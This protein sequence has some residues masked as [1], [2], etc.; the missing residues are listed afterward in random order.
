MAGALK[1]N[2][3]MQLCGNLRVLECFGLLS[4]QAPLFLKSHRGGY[5]YMHLI[6]KRRETKDMAQYPPICERAG[7]QTAGTKLQPFFFFLS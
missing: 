5:A 3:K 4:C 2:L 6:F 1:C 7:L